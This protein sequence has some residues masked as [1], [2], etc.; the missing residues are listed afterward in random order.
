MQPMN[1]YKR[2]EYGTWYARIERCRRF[3]NGK[4]IA[5]KTTDQKEAL[6]I[7]RSMKKQWL[8]NRLIELDGSQRIS[9]KDFIKEYTEHPV[10]KHLA[11]DTLRLDRLALKSLGDV[12]GHGAAI[13]AINQQKINQFIKTCSARK[14]SNSTINTYLRHIRAA[15]NTAREWEYIEKTPKIKPIKVDK[16][17]P[18][19]LSRKEVNKILEYSKRVNHEMWRIITF[20]LWTGCRRQEITNLKWQD[21]TE[22]T[23]R[24]IGKGGKER[25]VYLL[26][27]ALKAMGTKRDIGPVFKR[28]HKDTVSHQFKALADACNIK[29]HFHNLR[30]TAATYMIKNSIPLEIIQ[31]ILGHSDIRTTQIYAQIYDDVIEKEM[32]KLKY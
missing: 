9:L 16:R 26:P 4:K 17:L 5:L 24:I 8:E 22:N 11:G 31:K 30:H 1:L 29:A 27:D 10:R 21:V 2:K 6:A 25:I 14:L 23:C 20:A 15:L 28:I 13:K 19:T 7:F 3:P 12:T 18:A 32:S